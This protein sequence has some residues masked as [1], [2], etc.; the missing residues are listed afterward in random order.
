MNERSIQFF[1]DRRVFIGDIH[2]HCGISYGHGPLDDALYNAALQLDFTAI[3]GHAGWPDMDDEPMPDVVADYHRQG[4]AKLRGNWEDYRHAVEQ[5]NNPGTFVTFF[6][7]E[8][9][10]FRYG[11]RTIITPLAPPAPITP[12]DPVELQSL[13]Q[14]HNARARNALLLPHHIGYRTGYRGIDWD[15][16]TDE[17]SPLVEIFSMHGSAESDEYARFP[18]MH[19]MGPLDGAHTM[20]AGLSEGH[21]FG[22]TASTDHHSA[23]PGSYGYGRTAV[24]AEE[25]TRESIWE[26]LLNRRTYALTGDR[27]EIAFTVAGAPLGSQTSA[28]PGPRRIEGSVRGGDALDRL[29]ILRNNR[30]IHREVFSSTG[31]TST[32]VAG[33]VVLEFGWGPKG[34]TVAWDITIEVVGGELTNVEPRLR[35][36]DVVDPLDTSDRPF[37]LSS[38]RRISSNQI[39]LE[40]MTFGNRTTTTIQ[41]QGIALEL[42]A[43]ERT[44]LLINANGNSFNVPITDIVEHSRGFY[45]GGFTSPAIRVHRFVA[46][47][48]R[49]AVFDFDDESHSTEPRRPGG[50]HEA[51]GPGEDWY[52]LRV[53]QR[54]GHAAWTSPVWV[55]R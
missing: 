38:W 27:M 22:V 40:T 23:H 51:S 55:G 24:W 44:H 16:V 33:L 21:H 10:S 3:T 37:R 17:A 50:T 43:T 11:D 25:L 9:H 7:Y 34:E 19:T 20:Q 31:S 46:D 36:V 41:T 8:F 1:S 15:S 47:S 18:Y 28:V 29:E 53:F 26:A 45:T 52:Y 30:V 12:A 14:T 32:S 49:E 2:N 39:H 13:L 6:S 4:F 54:N 35:G 42:V 5:Y 48:E